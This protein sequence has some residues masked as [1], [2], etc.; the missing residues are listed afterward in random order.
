MSSAGKKS[1][2]GLNHLNE[3]TKF[4]MNVEKFKIKNKLICFALIN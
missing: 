2:I 3:A 1:C 4:C